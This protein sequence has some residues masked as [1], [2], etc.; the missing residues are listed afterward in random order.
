MQSAGH[1]VDHSVAPA[2]GASVLVGLVG[3]NIQRSRTP[4]MHEAEGARLG[5]RYI[6]KL[7]DTGQKS[8]EGAEIG[9]IF[10]AARMCGF[11]GLNVTYPFKQT[12]M[13]HLDELAESAARVGAVNTVVFE[14]GRAVGHNTDEWGF[15][16]GFRREMKGARLGKVLQLG[17]GGAGAAVAS[18]LVQLGVRELFITDIDI[19]RAQDLAE[20]LS[21][22]PSTCAIRPLT[23]AEALERRFDG[24]V[25]TTPVGMDKT[26]GMPLSETV[27]RPD[28]WVADI[29]YFPLETEL[30]RTAAARGCR[31][32][33]GA[34]MAVFQ[35]VRAFE[36][37]TGLPADGIRMKA[38]FDAFTG[39][40]RS[41]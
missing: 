6:Y 23:L 11:A 40:G 24:V 27:L 8:I 15:A 35:A 26:P 30:L 1:I 7:L 34:A 31:T 36:L 41:P 39:G 38:T 21:V 10:R 32:F 33:S 28:M 13:P 5:L 18:A 25:N 3:R 19:V 12:I 22:A 14:N 29:I 37:F 20:R 9:E 16:E 17:A 2:T 4:G